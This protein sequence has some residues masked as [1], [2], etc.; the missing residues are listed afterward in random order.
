M[1]VLMLALKHWLWRANTKWSD[2][3]SPLGVDAESGYFCRLHQ[4][5]HLDLKL[6]TETTFISSTGHLANTVYLGELPLK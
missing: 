4:K 6:C 1:L 5:D 3:L 2:V